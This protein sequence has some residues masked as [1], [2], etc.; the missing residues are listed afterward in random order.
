M[1]LIAELK[2]IDRL[3]D[4]SDAP[5]MTGHVALAR[6]PALHAGHAHA[7]KPLASCGPLREEGVQSAHGE[8]G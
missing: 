8:L 2:Y 4:A 5:R 6:G 7:Q 3:S 1:H